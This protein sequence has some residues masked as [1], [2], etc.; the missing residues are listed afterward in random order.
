MQ[1]RRPLGSEMV[2]LSSV[3]RSNAARG[4]AIKADPYSKPEQVC[5]HTTAQVKQVLLPVSQP[6]EEAILTLCC[7]QWSLGE[8]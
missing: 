4:L 1:Q 2:G 7:C 3:A 6:A 5:R 8:S